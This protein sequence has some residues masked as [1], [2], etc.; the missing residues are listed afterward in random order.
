M[1][2]DSSFNASELGIKDLFLTVWRGK[3]TIAFCVI[4][5]ISTAIALYFI[6][7][8]KFES[9]VVAGLVSTTTFSE[10]L[11]L[12][13]LKVFNYTPDSLL[14]EYS[15]RFS[16]FDNLFAMAK[17]S[18]V[19]ARDAMTDEQYD[20]ELQK[21]VAGLSIE[22]KAGQP[23]AGKLPSLSLVARSGEP[24]P[25]FSFVSG[26]LNET[27]T[28]MAEDIAKEIRRTAAVVKG[29]QEFEIDRLSLDVKSSRMRFDRAR[30]DESV[31]ISEQS[32]I[33]RS[34][35]IDK[36]I[37]L[38]AFETAQPG[39]ASM[40]INSASVT[41]PYLNGYL[42]LDEKIRILSERK[43]NDAF[44][45]GL[46]ENEQKIYVLQNDPLSDRI[47]RLLEQSPLKDPATAKLVTFSTASAFTQKVF[48]RLS[49]FLPA[50][51]FIGLLLGVGI[52]LSRDM[53]GRQTA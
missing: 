45:E 18:G 36:P 30:Q 19:V 3:I 51:A 15:V 29:Q 16:D 9:R 31:R 50:G 6:V 49:I 43:D 7:P 20:Y 13:D 8:R 14:Q 27:M 46:R 47:V 41:E 5:S 42:A 53:F 22:Y 10:Y 2:M 52:V 1:S 40:Q 26:Q 48:P 25:L 21:F 17:K 28:T 32:A 34:L 38:K 39:A 33:A 4:L 11:A 37:E 44:V 23:E 12:A 24:G 35:N